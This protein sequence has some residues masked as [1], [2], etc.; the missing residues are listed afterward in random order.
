MK[1]Y[2]KITICGLITCRNFVH[3]REKEKAIKKEKSRTETERE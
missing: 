1:N 2:V 3:E